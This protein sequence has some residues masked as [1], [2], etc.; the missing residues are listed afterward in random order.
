[1]KILAAI[2]TVC[3]VVLP[4]RAV[5]LETGRIKVVMGGE[6]PILQYDQNPKF[7]FEVLA[8][9]KDGW[10][11]RSSAVRGDCFIYD[12][13]VGEQVL[14]APF[15]IYKCTSQDSGPNV[16][17]FRFQFRWSHSFNTESG[18]TVTLMHYGWVSL[19]TDG[20]GNVQVLASQVADVHGLA[21]VGQDEPNPPQAPVEVTWSYHVAHGEWVELDSHCIPETTAG[22]IEIPREIEGKPVKVI[23]DAAFIRCDRVTSIIIPDTIVNIGS[24][25]F[26]GCNSLTSLTIPASVTNVGHQIA[27]NATNLVLLTIGCGQATYAEAAFAYTFAKTIAI[28]EGMASIDKWLFGGNENLEAI[29]VPQ[30][31]TNV[32]EGAFADCRKLARA[33]VFIGTTI[34]GGAFPYDCKVIQYGPTTIVD[35]DKDLRSCEKQSLLRILGTP[36][37]QNIHICPDWDWREQDGKEKPIQPDNA[38]KVCVQLGISPIET[39]V[40]KDGEYV[41]A[42]FRIPKLEIVKLD[43]VAHTVIGRVIPAVGT[44]IVQ[45]PQTY[46][47]GINYVENFGSSYPYAKELGW[48]WPYNQSGCP[49]KLDL[50]NYTKTGEFTYTYDPAYVYDPDFPTIFQLVIGDY[51]LG[52]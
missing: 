21:V 11:V 14:D 50:S 2:L 38:A 43:P 28:G 46:V 3:L 13:K 51:N 29:T 24:Q 8:W 10:W 42:K 15:D 39:N 6:Y 25:A 31:V 48:W 16:D 40:S 35:G 37:A 4:A 36:Y 45:P 19:I 22:A 44:S 20:N 18:G 1:M 33:Y 47:F 49:L 23:S 12:A 26:N 27:C 9:G 41:T 5:T 34:E 17:V 52:D 32:E 7:R 30:S